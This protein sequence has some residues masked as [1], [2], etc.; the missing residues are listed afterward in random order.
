VKI[1]QSPI[2]LKSCRTSMNI[3]EQIVV[4]RTKNWFGLVELKVRLRFWKYNWWSK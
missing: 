2:G 4:L 3:R 1:V